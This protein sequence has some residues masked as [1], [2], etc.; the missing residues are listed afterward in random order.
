MSNANKNIFLIKCVHSSKYIHFMLNLY[1]KK[2]KSDFVFIGLFFLWLPQFIRDH[3]LPLDMEDPKVLA[4][5]AEQLFQ[6]HLPESFSLNLLTGDPTTPVYSL[7]P[8]KPRTRPYSNSSTS[9][10]TTSGRSRTATRG[11]CPLSPPPAGS[12][13]HTK[14]KPGSKSNPAPGWKTN[15]PA[16]WNLPASSWLEN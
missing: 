16:G 2:F 15:R 3:L 8:P 10:F 11:L 7:R 9:Q 13:G 1:P 5:K 14:T 6:S 12:T 4:K